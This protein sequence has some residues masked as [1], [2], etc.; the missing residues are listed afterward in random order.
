[1]AR[2]KK[3]QEGC[4]MPRKSKQS[5]ELVQIQKSPIPPLRQSTEETMSCPLFYAEVFIKGKKVPGGMDAARGTEIHKTMAAYLSHC[6]RKQVGMDLNAFESFSRGAGPQ[7][8]KILAGLRDGF[9]VDYDHLF[10]TELMMSLDES[11]DPTDLVSELQGI[12]RDSELPAAHQGTLDGVYIFRSE[13][14]I[15]IDDFKS[16]ARPF[17]PDDK[18]QGKK[19]ALFIFKHFAW[20]EKVTF[21]LTFVR[22]KNLTRSVIYT[23]DQVPMLVEVLKAAR[24]RQ[25]TI[26]AKHDA[27]EEI[28]AIP[29]AHCTYCPLLSDRSCPIAEFNPQLQL[30]PEDR[31]KFHLWYAAFSKVNNSAL[32]DYVNGTGKNVILKDYNQKIY[33]YGPVESESD[34]LPLFQP[35]ADG[36]VIDEQGNPS[37]PIISLLMDYAHSTPDDTAWMA[38]LVISSTAM[39]SYLKAKKRAFLDQAVSDTAEK[40]TKVKLKVSKPLDAIPEEVEDEDREEWDEEGEEF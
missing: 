24:A 23:R 29:G 19:Y 36:I 17:D 8:H 6:A 18:P 20:A 10:A 4:I 21:R 1:M 33:L 9:T 28:E 16:H 38:K 25:E 7:A 30:S 2:H 40:V 5:T 15:L 35:T 13:N 26:H 39:K 14:H 37:M 11:L 3:N 27:G 32:K 12:L 22:Y 34:V 31:L